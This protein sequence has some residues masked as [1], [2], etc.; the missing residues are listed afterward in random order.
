MG[1]RTGA[2][3]LASL[4]GPIGRGSIN[5]Q[6]CLSQLRHVPRADYI[7]PMDHNFPEYTPGERVADA[8]IHV[9]G[10]VGS[11]AAAATLTTVAIL[12]LPPLSTLSIVVYSLGMVAVFAFSAGYNLVGRPGLKALLRR[13]DHAAIYVKIAATYTPFA[14]V[15]MGGVAG[16]GLLGAVWA[17][18]LFGVAAKL[19]WPAQLARTSY[20]LYLAQGWACVAALQPLAA[21]LPGSALILLV[22]GGVLY[23]MGVVFHL[24]NSLPY[25]NAIWHG[26]VLVASACHFAAVVDAVALNAA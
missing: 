2:P 1:P 26:F 14:L 5:P 24:W 25:H 12:Y 19:F 13:F 10:V 17:V 4:R 3:A 8:C 16:F 20:V 15:K 11:L 18:G 22:S 7:D 21:A 6:G 23:T 9:V